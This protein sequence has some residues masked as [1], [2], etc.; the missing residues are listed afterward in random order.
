L[1]SRFGP[2]TKDLE[3]I[4]L[5]EE[6]GKVSCQIVLTKADKTPQAKR[7]E[8]IQH[9]FELIKN[10][11]CFLPHI[12]PTSSHNLEGI[13]DLRAD[14]GRASGLSVTANST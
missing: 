11:S 7:N 12:I 2:Q 13:D 6:I 8:V 10:K 3:F 5:L 9:I 14:L 4:E 1:D